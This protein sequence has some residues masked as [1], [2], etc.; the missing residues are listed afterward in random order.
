MEP[1]ILDDVFGSVLAAAQ[2]MRN[3][4]PIVS[5]FRLI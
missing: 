4:G 2:F 1:D 3:I 5:G